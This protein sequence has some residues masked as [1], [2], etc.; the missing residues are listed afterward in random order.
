MSRS[1][2]MRH[3]WYEGGHPARHRPLEGRLRV[4]DDG[5][6]V[7]SWRGSVALAWDAVTGIGV[8]EPAE[9]QLRDSWA[10]V[11]FLGPLAYFVPK[12]IR[13]SEI[14]VSTADGEFVVMIDRA[15]PD[16]VRERL[17]DSDWIARAGRTVDPYSTA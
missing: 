15:E 2:S 6:V 10:R 1:V 9:T 8:R 16:R 17:R 11:W 12:K 3:A 4:H 7:R 13:A 5:I 14:V